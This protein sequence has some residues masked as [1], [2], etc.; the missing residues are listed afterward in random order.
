MRKFFLLLIFCGNYAFAQNAIVEESVTEVECE[1]NTHMTTHYKEV[2][3]ILNE[4]GASL[5]GFV[6]SCGK[7]DKLTSFKGQ[8]TDETGKVI[9]K[10]KES[11]L[12]HTE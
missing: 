9:R 8:V 4:Q 5:A 3:T 2:T 12:E 1:S 6:C 7:K 11:D 10:I